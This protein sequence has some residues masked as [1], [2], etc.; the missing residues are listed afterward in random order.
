M[1]RFFS[2]FCHISDYGTQGFN[3]LP[4][5]IEISYPLVLW[6]PP[7][8]QV[9]ECYRA[10]TCL[11]PP[12]KL[13]EYVEKGFIHI[14][15]RE[16]WLLDESYRRH[17]ADAHPFATW[18]DNFDGALK[19]IWHTQQNMP[20]NQRSII[21]ASEADGLEWAKQL[22]QEEPERI[23]PIWERI[24]TKRIPMVSL[25]RIQQYTG[26]KEKSVLQVLSDVRNHTK[27]IHDIDADLPFL[28]HEN[29]SRFFRFLEKSGA[30]KLPQKKQFFQQGTQLHLIQE[31]DRLLSYIKH[32]EKFSSLDDFIGSEAH[33]DLAKWLHSTVNLAQ[34]Y[35]SRQRLRAF[36]VGQ[37]RHD[38]EQ[39]KPTDNPWDIIGSSRLEKMVNVGGL[40]TGIAS[41]FFGGLAFDPST[42]LSIGGLITNT[43]PIL[44]GISGRLGILRTNYNGPQWPY[45]VRFNRNPKKQDIGEV[46]AILDTLLAVMDEK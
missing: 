46:K 1:E 24:E 32:P 4:Q 27:A 29:D 35:W 8:S 31:S 16:K 22:I 38:I 20:K 9:N 40:I 14:V 37:L 25:K 23:D 28:L 19:S 42:A 34:F 44:T 5:M 39:R 12:A 41:L 33:K 45:L 21:L 15:G 26:D 43:V 3:L 6:A 11:L 17:Y 10:G 2:T 30:N 18:H 36:M 7:G 13:I